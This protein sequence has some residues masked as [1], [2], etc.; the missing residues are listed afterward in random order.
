MKIVNIIAK[1]DK[2]IKNEC[3]VSLD[4]LGGEFCFDVWHTTQ[5]R[6]KAYWVGCN[7]QDKTW[8]GYKIYFLDDIPV[9]LEK[10]F[11]NECSNTSYARPYTSS[12]IY[13]WFSNECYL[14]VRDYLMSL[15]FADNS[16]PDYID[17]DEDIDG[18]Y[19]IETNQGIMTDHSITFITE[20]LEST[21]NKVN[22][23]ELEDLYRG[24]DSI[25]KFREKD[26]KFTLL[27]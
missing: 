18:L 23:K 3:F 17:I 1:L 7:F 27:E 12:N 21:C 10:L 9:C 13:F 24:K 14:K 19:K 25:I 4:D 20:S 8:Y 22:P 6:L 5:D 16:D 2:S 15:V 26:I 11:N